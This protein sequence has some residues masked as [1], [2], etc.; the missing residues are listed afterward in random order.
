MTTD[1]PTR[2]TN[3]ASSMQVVEQIQSR[4]KNE[5]TAGDSGVTWNHDN[6]GHRRYLVFE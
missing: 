1:K 6:L 5:K 2:I 3:P 4:V